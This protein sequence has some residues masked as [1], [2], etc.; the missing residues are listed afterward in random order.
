MKIALTKSGTL[1]SLLTI[2]SSQRVFP[3]WAL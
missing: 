3:G 1:L 2:P